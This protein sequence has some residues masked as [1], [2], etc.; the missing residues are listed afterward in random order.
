MQINPE[1]LWFIGVTALCVFLFGLW[2]IKKRWGKL[3]ETNPKTGK[4]RTP[5]GGYVFAALKDELVQ[6]SLI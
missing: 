2:W 6:G 5:L 4:K 3:P 1:G